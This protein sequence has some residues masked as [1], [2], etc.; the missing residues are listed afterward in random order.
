LWKTTTG[1]APGYFGAVGYNLEDLG[2]ALAADNR[3]V[4]CAVEQSWELLLRRESTLADNNALTHHREAFLQS[5]LSYKA[6]LLSILSDPRYRSG[7]TDEPG[8]TPLKMA[9]PDLLASQVEELTG[10]AWTYQDFDMLRSDT[11]GLRVLA[12][13]TDGNTVTQTALE[14]NTTVVL[15][16]ERLAHAAAWFVTESDAA[17]G[18]QLFHQ[19]DFTE[20]LDS[21]RTAMAAQLQDL[22]W[23][24]FGQRVEIDGE[25]VNANLA[26]WQELF[27]VTFDPVNAWAGVLSVLLRD[28][29]FLLY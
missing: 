11:V 21:D 4:E 20:T 12:G 28:P 26:L 15:V 23:R 14:P 19:I 25:E 27:D 5:G 8:Y 22:H 16:Q 2:Q 1:T 10:F 18:N 6:L 13:G 7:A 24:I 29:D 9:T 17:G 3:F